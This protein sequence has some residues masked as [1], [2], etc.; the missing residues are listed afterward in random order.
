[1]KKTQLKIEVISASAGT[2]KTYTLVERLYNELAKNGVRPECV[3]GTTFTVAAANELT[4]RVRVKLFEAGE[5]E[6]A[7]AVRQAKFGTVNSIC[8]FLVRRYAFFAGISPELEVL[9]EA[10]QSTDFSAATSVILGRYESEI[11]PIARRLGFSKWYP[12]A[13]D[14]K[15]DVL[16]LVAMMRT[17]NFG[18]DS[19]RA[20]RDES[21]KTLL[22]MIGKPAKLTVQKFEE[23]LL[24]SL[25]ETIEAIEAVHDEDEDNVHAAL[26]ALRNAERTIKS[27]HY[28]YAD[29]EDFSKIR[30]KHKKKVIA[31]KYRTMTDAFCA[32]ASNYRAHPRL[33]EDIRA[34]IEIVYKAAEEA[35]LAY[36][37]YKRRRGII[38][39]IDQE[40]LAL[41]VLDHEAVQ[42]D[43][44]ARL[45]LLLVDEFQDT[46]PLQLAIFL[47]LSSLAKRSI[48]VGDPKQCIYGFREADPRLMAAVVKR[49]DTGKSENIL[50]DSWRSRPSLV[51]FFNR[52]FTASFAGEF[53]KE[54]VVL[55]P[56]RKNA[57]ATEKLMPPALNV[58]HLT[59]KNN[60]I[61]AQKIAAQ[62]AE[63]L[64]S[65]I[66]VD[67]KG[68]GRLRELKGNDVAVLCRSNA[69]CSGIANALAEYGVES[70][71]AASGLFGTVEG[72]LFL[73]ALRLVIDA[74]DSLAR[75]EIH[76]LFE[77][78]GNDLEWLNSRLDFVEKRKDRYKEEWLNEY[79]PIAALLKL[80]E[81]AIEYTVSE[82][83]NAIIECIDLRSVAVSY[84]NAGQR[85]A[86]IESLRAYALDFEEQC[87]QARAP[88]SISAWYLH[89]DA[90]QSDE[91]DSQAVNPSENAVQV[92]T[93]HG[94]KGLEWPV[95]YLMSIA[96][97]PRNP[98]WRFT[99]RETRSIVDLD[100][101]LGGRMP[102]FFP[103]FMGATN[104][105]VEWLQAEVEQQPIY[106][107]LVRDALDEDKRLLYVGMT[108]ARD[109]LF[110]PVR[111]AGKDKVPQTGW[112][113]RCNEH[114]ADSYAFL[115]DGSIAALSTDTGDVAVQHIADFDAPEPAPVDPQPVNWFTERKGLAAHEPYFVNPSQA[116]NSQGK[117]TF[118]VAEYGKRMT[119][120]GKVEMDVLGSALHAFLAA[121]RPS[122]T[123]AQRR[124]MLTR[125][126]TGYGVEKSIAADA[127]LEQASA[128]NTYIT[129][130]FA[131]IALH[132]EWPLQMHM[133]QQFM[134]GIADLILETAAGYVIIDHKSYAGAA[135]Q[136]AEKA[137]EYQG[138]L[139]SYQRALEAATGKKVVGMYVDFFTLGAVVG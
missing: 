54:R 27:G 76:L 37:D 90:L 47:K 108:R 11:G 7:L 89:L 139:E 110:F 31:D 50:G 48:W 94:A 81:R 129:N 59:A 88:S 106:P 97:E 64:K 20:G 78:K 49:F 29:L 85:L 95:V 102:L 124:E 66:K 10:E 25:S 26:D 109:Y 62:I 103:W 33:G 17:N 127:V 86:N 52:Y 35:L 15:D 6:L 104:K 38:D 128:F 114:D 126:L 14:W 71:V 133:G 9:G 98:F 130:T 136:L 67:Q 4:E 82:M 107:D 125:I 134:N 112:I 117:K 96:N 122:L 22:A 16:T 121:D 44:A 12:T 24:Q 80:R 13:H 118:T 65:G 57:S 32:L 111:Y 28:A 18:A 75:A 101:L 100:D 30:I 137:A 39:F 51:N 1:M 45:D 23:Q 123:D 60:N 46:S 43:V 2:G 87:R 19:L 69:E 63:L 68:E 36:D 74:R 131:P 132:R 113:N 61:Y 135:N 5:T 119:I 99:I 40:V 91:A 105:K 8:D 58:L 92:M 115:T 93:Y 56:K 77:G 42:A 84:G 70:V 120:Q 138:Q 55:K 73:A 83:A 41:K 34:Y 21:I 72:A 3:I 79:A 116:E 53:D